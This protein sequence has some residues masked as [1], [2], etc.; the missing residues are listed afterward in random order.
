L[1][2]EDS[3][4][5]QPVFKSKKGNISHKDFVIALKK[6]GIES[7][8]TLFLHTQLMAFG[9]LNSKIGKT[10]TEIFDLIIDV[11]NEVIGDSGNLLMTTF[12]SQT[13]HSRK[14]DISSTPSEGG[15]LTEYF[16]TL[17]NV[18]RSL[19]PTHSFAMSGP[20]NELLNIDNSVFGD[21]SIYGKLY[22]KNATLL[23][24]GARFHYCT[25]NHYIE[26]KANVSYRKKRSVKFE[27]INGNSV[28]HDTYYQYFKSNRFRVN[29]DKLERRLVEKGLLKS[30]NIGSGKILSVKSRDLF[31]TGY[32]L[33]KED[34]YGFLDA[35]P[36][37]SYWTTELKSHIKMRLIKLLLSL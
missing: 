1:L 24:F 7:G 16:R 2:T 12:S 35:K 27:L 31:D 4:K 20:D 9:R 19:H 10:R 8:D 22:S 21:D 14:F 34:K 3:I 32:Q 30:V 15:V 23:F 18:N 33:L 6:L 29:F 11:L 37:L 36:L 13:L 17:P 25:F 5:E 28:K 26:E